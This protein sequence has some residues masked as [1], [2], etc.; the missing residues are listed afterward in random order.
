[1]MAQRAAPPPVTAAVGEVVEA[2]A[3]NEQDVLLQPQ[4]AALPPKPAEKAGCVF[5]AVTRCPWPFLL[6]VGAMMLWR[7]GVG[8]CGPE[9]PSEGIDSCVIPEISTA[10]DDFRTRG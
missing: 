6:T 8:V 7:A 3:V 10:V 1:M 9:F 5:Q 2:P 4:Y